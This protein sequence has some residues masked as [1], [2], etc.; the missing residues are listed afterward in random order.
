MTSEVRYAEDSGDASTI[1]RVMNKL[2]EVKM[3]VVLFCGGQGLRLRD[4]AENIPKPLV[5]IRYPP[6]LWHV[7]KDF[8]HFGHRDFIPCLRYPVDL[9]E[10]F[11]LNYSKLHSNDFVVYDGAH[12]GELA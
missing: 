6:I 3:K 8:A 9:I 10:Q 2:R 11:F 7:M 1:K 4:Y 12:R 5:T